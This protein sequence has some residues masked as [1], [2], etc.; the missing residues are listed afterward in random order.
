MARAIRESA[1]VSRSRL[2]AEVGVHR[3]TVMRWENGSC[4][5]RGA[6]LVRYVDVLT[7]L[8]SAMAGAA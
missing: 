8:Q 4:S 2:A 5:P 6:T 3:A 7:E 1:G